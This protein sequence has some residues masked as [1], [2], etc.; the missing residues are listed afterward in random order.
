MWH[1]F[2]YAPLIQSFNKPQI[3][4]FSKGDL[5]QVNLMASWVELISRQ[6]AW[7]SGLHAAAAII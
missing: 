1:Q 4:S 7:S 5:R 3:R 6:A 2:A